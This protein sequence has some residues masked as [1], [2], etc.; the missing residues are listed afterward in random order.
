[1]NP[2]KVLVERAKLLA[3]QEIYVEALSNHEVPYSFC[4]KIKE[5]INEIEANLDLENVEAK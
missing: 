5:K 4:L 1:M 2:A 3:I